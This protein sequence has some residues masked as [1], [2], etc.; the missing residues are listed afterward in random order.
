MQSRARAWVLVALLIAGCGG[1]GGGGA[2]APPATTPPATTTPGGTNPIS[3]GSSVP[4]NAKTAIT[5]FVSGAGSMPATAASINLPA[6]ATPTQALVFA[7]DKSNNVL[8]L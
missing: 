1:G 3:L 5:A 7:T 6:G 4:S 8:L 2:G